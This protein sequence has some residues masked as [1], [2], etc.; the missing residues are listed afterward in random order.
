LPQRSSDRTAFH[1]ERGTTR[2]PDSPNKVNAI[3]ECFNCGSKG[4]YRRD[5]PRYIGTRTSQRVP[6]NNRYKRRGNPSTFF[7]WCI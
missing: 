1:K 6:S 5:C 3:R 2:R 4:H 7:S